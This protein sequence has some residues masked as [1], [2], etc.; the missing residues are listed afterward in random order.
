MEWTTNL[1]ANRNL[2]SAVHWLLL[3]EH[4][5][6]NDFSEPQFF[7]LSL[8]GCAS[9]EGQPGWRFLILSTTGILSGVILSCELYLLCCVLY[10]SSQQH[11][12]VDGKYLL[13]G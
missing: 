1:K 9:G 8:W 7:V 10:T 4:E 11:Y 2:G 12:L 6:I 5:H 13:V 3:G